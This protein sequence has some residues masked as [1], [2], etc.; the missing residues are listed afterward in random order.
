MEEK[1]IQRLKDLLKVDR[2]LVWVDKKSIIHRVISISHIEDEPSEVAFIEGNY[3][4]ALYCC[5]LSDFAEIN[6]LN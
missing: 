2:E 6:V 5:N 1:E 4:L 3:Y